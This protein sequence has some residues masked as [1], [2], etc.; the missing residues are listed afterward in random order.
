M[1]GTNFKCK[2]CGKEYRCCD[3]GL[4]KHPYKQIVCSEDCWHQWLSK[5]NK[6]DKATE[7]KVVAEPVL[8]T[9]EEVVET[10]ENTQPIITEETPVVHTAKRK[11]KE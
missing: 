10:V 1:A 11:I 2:I 4:R 5:V 3:I 8:E 9:V 6:T 7:V